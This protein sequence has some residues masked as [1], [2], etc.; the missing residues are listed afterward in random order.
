[1]F[2]SSMEINILNNSVLKLETKEAV[3][4]SFIGSCLK[5]F[6]L[7]LCKTTFQTSGAVVLNAIFKTSRHLPYF[8]Y[9]NSYPLFERR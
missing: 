8:H 7:L 4:R 6:E 2:P 1:M 3:S 9:L 5:D